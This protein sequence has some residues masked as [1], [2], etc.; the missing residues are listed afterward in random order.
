MRGRIIVNETA[1]KLLQSSGT[2]PLSK[3]IGTS[4]ASFWRHRLQGIMQDFYC[5][6]PTKR[7]QPLALLPSKYLR[8]GR[9]FMSVRLAEGNHSEILTKIEKT[10]KRFFPKLPFEY[11]YV[12]KEMEKMHAQKMGYRLIALVFVTGFSLF[13][14]AVGLFAARGYR[15]AGA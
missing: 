13:I 12:A 2:D 1:R 8:M 4:S 11:K 10:V 3:S 9:E 6:Y 14:A 15:P 5:F 7:I